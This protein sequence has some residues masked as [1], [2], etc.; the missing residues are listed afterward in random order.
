MLSEFPVAMRYV[1]CTLATWRLTHLIVA[2]DGPWDIVVRLRARLGESPAG[3]A[4]DCFYCSS[5]WL[6]LPFAFVIGRDV[7]GFL[8]SWLA[9]SGAASLLEQATNRNM[10]RPPG[11]R[12]P[13]SE[14]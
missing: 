13:R 9:I 2:E 5:I 12:P 6:A 8:V 10:N 14:N 3:R 1:L 7:P 4:M 11:P